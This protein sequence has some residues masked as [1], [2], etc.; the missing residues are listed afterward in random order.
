[1]LRSLQLVNEQVI[2]NLKENE[3]IV[4]IDG[5]EFEVVDSPVNGLT[6]R[7]VEYSSENLADSEIVTDR[8]LQPV[9]AIWLN[10]M[11]EMGKTFEVEECDSFFDSVEIDGDYIN[12]YH[13]NLF[14]SELHRLEYIIQIHEEIA[15][16]FRVM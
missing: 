3:M 15:K 11:M 7:F 14:L 6:F 4:T 10:Q 5:E 1:M 12:G 8:V 16:K 2:F 9:K 13:I